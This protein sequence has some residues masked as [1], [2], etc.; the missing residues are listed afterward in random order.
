MPAKNKK[1]TF[2]LISCREKIAEK[3][4]VPLPTAPHSAIVETITEPTVTA[5]KKVRSFRRVLLII[6]VYLIKL[7]ER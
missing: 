4:Y 2:T 1:T 5:T 3:L 7:E 6:D